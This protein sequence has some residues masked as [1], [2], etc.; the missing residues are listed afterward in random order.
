MFLKEV[1]YSQ[2]QSL[3]LFDPQEKNVILWNINTI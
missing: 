2:Q 3:H 1:S